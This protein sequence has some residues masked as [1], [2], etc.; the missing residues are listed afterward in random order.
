ML[1]CLLLS[2]ERLLSTNLYLILTQN[3]LFILNTIAQNRACLIYI[4]FLILFLKNKKKQNQKENCTMSLGLNTARMFLHLVF[5]RTVL[6]IIMSSEATLYL[7]CTVYQL[8]LRIYIIFLL[9]KYQPHPKPF[10]IKFLYKPQTA[11]SPQFCSCSKPLTG[12]LN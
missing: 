1:P 2:S 9:L 11:K 7:K 4:F 6:V 12:R 3:M 10:S 8:I 5:K